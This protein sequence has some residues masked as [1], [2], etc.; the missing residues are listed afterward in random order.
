M[1]FN[2]YERNTKVNTHRANGIAGA[3]NTFNPSRPNDQNGLLHTSTNIFIYAND[4][5]VGMIQSFSVS[6]SRNIN[7]LQAIGYEGVVQAVPSNTN[8]GQL[9]VTR[10]ALYNSNIF[11]ALGLTS[12]GTS[13]NPLGRKVHGLD[14]TYADKHEAG[15]SGPEMSGIGNNNPSSAGFVFRTLRDQRVPI[16]IKVKSPLTGED[17]GYYEER[18]VDCWLSSFSKSFTVSQ[19]TVAE[20]ATIQYGDVY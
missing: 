17:S 9:S 3:N 15:H 8:G 20:N 11:R 14:N 16:E 13:G 19:I 2:N 5:I 4:G 12:T 6:E 7:K 10:M 1:A 18:Y